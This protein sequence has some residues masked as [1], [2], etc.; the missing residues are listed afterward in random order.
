MKRV[1]FCMGYFA[2]ELLPTCFNQCHS[3][4][5]KKQKK[6]SL[7]FLQWGVLGQLVGWQAKLY[8]QYF[9][10]QKATDGTI[11][12]LYILCTQKK[13][14]WLFYIMLC[15]TF[16]FVTNIFVFPSTSFNAF[17]DHAF[18]HKTVSGYLTASVLTQNKKKITIVNFAS[19][20]DINNL[21]AEIYTGCHIKDMNQL[22]NKEVHV[23]SRSISLPL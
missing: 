12:C 17:L 1:N 13:S 21:I 2:E 14:K 19:K 15:Y 3:N 20:M 18:M 23:T 10:Q 5:T 8:N 9:M 16:F 11:C 7:L 22:S 6:K 4:H